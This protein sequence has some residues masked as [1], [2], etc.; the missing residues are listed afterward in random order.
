MNVMAENWVLEHEQ[1]GII[2]VYT[3]LIIWIYNISYILKD[4]VKKK[5]K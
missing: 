3:G 4:Q 2:F 1:P 5:I